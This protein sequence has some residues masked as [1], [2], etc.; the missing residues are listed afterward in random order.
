MLSLRAFLPDGQFKHIHF[1]QVFKKLSI[2]LCQPVYF[3][4][5]QDRFHELI[6]KGGDSDDCR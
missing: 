6:D 2:L 1:P 4:L 3:V 5:S